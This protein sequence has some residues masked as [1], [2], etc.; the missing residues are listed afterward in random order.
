MLN[1]GKITKCCWLNLIIKASCLCTL[2]LYLFLSA[3]SFAN[4]C[5]QLIHLRRTVPSSV[6]LMCAFS[7]SSYLAH[8]AVFLRRMQREQHKKW[9]IYS[10]QK[11]ASDGFPRTK[12]T[13]SALVTPRLVCSVC[14]RVSHI[15]CDAA[16]SL[17]WMWSALVI[18]RLLT[19]YITTNQLVWPKVTGV[20][21]LLKCFNEVQL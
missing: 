4:Y 15:L 5:A 14:A 19:L 13:L 3:V 11:A 2:F 6:N 9:H 7:T 17:F 1:D 8:V 18:S 20:F 10:L 21:M 12:S 16:D